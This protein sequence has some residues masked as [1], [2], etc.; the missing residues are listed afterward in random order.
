MRQRLPFL[1]IVPSVLVVVVFVYGFILWTFRISLTSSSLLP[2]YDW[3]GV[4]QYKALFADER[5]WIASK[6][7]LIFGSLLIIISM[8][9]GLFIAILLDQKIRGEGF[10]RTVYLYPMSLSLVVSGVTWKWL[11]NPS[12]GI[13]NL[14][15]QLG[16][17]HFEFSWIIDPEMAIYT[18]VIAG[19][20]QVTGF[21]MVLFLAGLRR[22]DDSIIS[23]AKIDGAGL[24]RIYAQIIIPDLRP[25]FFSILLIL[26]HI[27][28]KSFDLVVALTNG[29]PGYA[30]DLPAVFMYVH[31]FNRNHIALGSSSAVVLLAGVLAIIIPYLYSQKRF[32]RRDA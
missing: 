15:I 2:I 12:L 14:M 1:V 16:F 28:I 24:F 23:A 22:I 20:W 26:F 25:I 17:E 9:L 32:E 7:I 31:T 10:L 13:E 4:S 21:V 30:T 27:V 18:V 8:S 5:W 6:N 11:L 29:G 19:V 3:V